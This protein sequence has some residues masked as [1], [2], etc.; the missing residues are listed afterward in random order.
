MR[1]ILLA[2]SLVALALPLAAPQ[3]ADAASCSS[4]KQTGTVIGGLGGALAGK[5]IGGGTTGL[6]VG[7]LGG[8]VAGH[9]I[10]RAGCKDR[11]VARST[12]YRREYREPAPAPARKVYYDQYG[13]PVVV[14]ER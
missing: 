13:K 4:R 8:A 10:G 9:E 5:V 12:T 2:A 3:T 14:H 11:R 7:G 6:V 1:R